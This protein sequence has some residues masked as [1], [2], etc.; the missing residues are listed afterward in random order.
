[1][2]EPAAVD[3]APILQIL[4]AGAALAA[5]ALAWLQLRARKQSPAHWLRA[6]T[7]LT[8][9]LTMVASLIKTRFSDSR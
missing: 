8:L 7:V 9:F 6:V 5:I 3:L 4:L 1:M 2:S